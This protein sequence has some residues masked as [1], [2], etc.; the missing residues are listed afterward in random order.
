M[1]QQQIQQEESKFWK[2]YG[3]ILVKYVKENDEFDLELILKDRP[4]TEFQA[5]ESMIDQKLNL[6]KE[7]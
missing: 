6:V 2:V 4:D 7:Q 3:E 1:N 5:L